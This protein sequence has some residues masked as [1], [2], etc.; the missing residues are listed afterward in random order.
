M[1]CK[2]TEDGGWCEASPISQL[3]KETNP[4]LSDLPAWLQSAVEDLI[5]AYSSDDLIELIKDI[6][7]VYPGQLPPSLQPLLMQVFNIIS[8]IL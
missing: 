4:Q 1:T 6:G 2:Q 5:K 3:I 7:E 8:L